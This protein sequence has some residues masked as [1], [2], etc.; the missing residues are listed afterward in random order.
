MNIAGRFILGSIGDRIGNRHTIIIVFILT[1]AALI[2][3]IPAREMW[4]LYLFAAA[5]G[6]AHGGMGPLGAPLVAE[7]FGLRSHGL[8]FGVMG[9]G[10]TIGGAAG[11]L[12]AGYIFDLTESYQLA[13]L[14]CAAISI[15]GLILIILLKPI[16]SS[17]RQDTVPSPI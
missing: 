14:S 11:P 13:F 3:L 1:L 2:W 16:S 7:L 15:I 17:S 10:F 8:L 5:F 12:L 9:L 4:M 6:L